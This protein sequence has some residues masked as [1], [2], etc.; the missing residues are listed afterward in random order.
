MVYVQYVYIIHTLRVHFYRPWLKMW[1]AQRCD[2]SFKTA[3]LGC[4]F[5]SFLQT[6]V[7]LH[8][9]SAAAHRVAE[10]LG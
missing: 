10:Q 9:S 8:Q 6:G 2:D 3:G 5:Y 1:T 7:S 4:L